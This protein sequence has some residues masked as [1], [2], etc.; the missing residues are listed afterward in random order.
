MND[1][2]D[3][4]YNSNTKKLPIFAIRLKTRKFW[5]EKKCKLEKVLN[6]PVKY[7]IQRSSYV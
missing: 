2:L 5:K 1:Q 3:T 6:F 4:K 7:N